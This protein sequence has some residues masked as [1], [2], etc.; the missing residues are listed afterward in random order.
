M[1]SN[2]D[3]ELKLAKSIWLG[4]ILEPQRACSVGFWPNFQ[5]TMWRKRA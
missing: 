1:S 3:Q 5:K 4:V 2:V